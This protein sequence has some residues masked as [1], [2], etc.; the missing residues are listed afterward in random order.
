MDPMVLFGGE[1][2]IRKEAQRVLDDYGVVGN[3]G[4]VFNLG[5]G[6]NKDTPPESVAILVDEVHTYSRKLHV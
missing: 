1:A 3:G 4:H 6:I 2:A 5:H